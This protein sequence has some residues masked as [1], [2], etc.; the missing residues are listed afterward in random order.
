MTDRAA[1][2]K[3][4]ASIDGQALGRN[5]G[6]LCSRLQPGTRVRAAVRV[7]VYGD[8]EGLARGKMDW[9][10][11]TPFGEG[12]E[13]RGTG[14]RAAVRVPFPPH[15]RTLREPTGTELSVA[16]TVC[17]D[18]RVREGP[19][20]S[21]ALRH[22]TKVGTSWLR[23]DVERF[24]KL[25]AALRFGNHVP[26]EGV[27]AHF[28]SAGRE[29]R[30][31]PATCG[32]RFLGPAT[33]RR[34]RRQKCLG[35]PADTLATWSSTQ[36]HLHLVRPGSLFC[37]LRLASG[38]GTKGFP[39]LREHKG[40]PKQLRELAHGRGVSCGQTFLVTQ[41][42]R[43]ATPSVG[44]AGKYGGSLPNSPALSGG[45]IARGM[46]ARSFAAYV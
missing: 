35:R 20:L 28:G 43:I 5:F 41:R 26:L 3:A 19:P 32:M 37:K 31:C 25:R 39:P 4:S 21:L 11:I 23:A 9:S 8:G 36:S 17:E 2:Y 12:W 10:R 29:I 46:C 16:V 7:N 27:F 34:Q 22:H 42:T 1:L 18:L 13:L 14:L 38:I 40:L 6:L 24:S 30:L 44:H 45:V 15:G 33:L